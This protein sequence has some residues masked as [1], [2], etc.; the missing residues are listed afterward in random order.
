MKTGTE[1]GSSARTE[2]ALNHRAISLAPYFTY[3]ACVS[4]HVYV[5]AH[6]CVEVTGQLWWSVLSFYNNDP[7]DWIQVLKLDSRYFNYWAISPIPLCYLLNHMNSQHWVCSHWLFPTGIWHNK[8]SLVKY[9]FYLALNRFLFRQLTLHCF[10][11][12]NWLIK[13][14]K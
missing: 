11:N 7:G 1:P 5:Y 14:L 10:T 12:K 3:V 9:P 4:S 8:Y 2:N 6:I 13:K